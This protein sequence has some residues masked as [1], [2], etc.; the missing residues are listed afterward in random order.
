MTQYNVTPEYVANAAADCDM[1]AQNVRTQLG[2]LR[3]LV[4]GL[5]ASW[6]GVSATQFAGLMNNFQIYSVALHDALTDI[7]Q[8]L[9]G[10]YVNYV[11]TEA[12]NLRNLV[13]IDG[14]LVGTP[15]D[16]SQP[17]KHVPPANL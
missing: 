17:N 11:N 14:G 16:T 6:L 8:G 9:R 5:G 1:T 3:T 2:L 10:N 13:S 7:G 4:E 15:G 12:D